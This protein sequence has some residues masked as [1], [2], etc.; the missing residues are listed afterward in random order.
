[1][2]PSVVERI[3]KML[4][5]YGGR[6]DNTKLVEAISQLDLTVYTQKENPNG[7]SFLVLTEELQKAKI[8]KRR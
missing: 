2:H 3:A 1:M 7:Q 8:E 4:D 5:L 6:K